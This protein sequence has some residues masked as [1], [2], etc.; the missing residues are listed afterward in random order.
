MSSLLTAKPI[1]RLNTSTGNREVVAQTRRC[2]AKRTL[3]GTTEPTG[4]QSARRAFS[5]NIPGSHR[6]IPDA[7]T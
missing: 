4:K 2:P 6:D 3:S 7:T 1:I 5:A